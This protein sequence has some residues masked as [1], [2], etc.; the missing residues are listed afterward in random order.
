MI[1]ELH[2]QDKLGAQVAILSL[3][4]PI[5]Y[6][7]LAGH[8]SNQFWAVMMSITNHGI[9]LDSAVPQPHT[10]QQHTKGWEL[11]EVLLLVAHTKAM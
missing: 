6:G 1:K 11:K 9:F 8:H 10:V 5:R 7:L 4:K 3:S 2:P